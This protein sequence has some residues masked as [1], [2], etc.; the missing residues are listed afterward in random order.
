MTGVQSKSLTGKDFAGAYVH[1]GMI[2]LDGEK[3]SKSKG[4]LVF[5]SKL[6]D[7]GMSPQV[8]RIALTMEHYQQDRM[9]SDENIRRAQA[10]STKIESVLSR[11]EVAP[12][13]YLVKEIV[14]SLADNL[15]TPRAYEAIEKWCD[16]TADGDEG[17]SA[18]EVSRTLDSY[19]GLAF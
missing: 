12:T 19:L 13:Q 9:W 17:G 10:L 18:G 2:G 15:D 11:S 16:R 8:I 7:A 3:M 4:N 6:L 14:D 5:V 1:A